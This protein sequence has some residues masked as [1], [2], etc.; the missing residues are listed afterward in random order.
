MAALMARWGK[1]LRMS[2]PKRMKMIRPAERGRLAVK[3][4]AIGPANAAVDRLKERKD[5]KTQA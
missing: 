2:N 3:V 4:S 1:V 5:G